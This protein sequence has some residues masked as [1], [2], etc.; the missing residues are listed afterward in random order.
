MKKLTTIAIILTATLF[1][2]NAFS[3]GMHEVNS[4]SSNISYAAPTMELAD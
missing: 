4:F 1:T 3:Y 2:T